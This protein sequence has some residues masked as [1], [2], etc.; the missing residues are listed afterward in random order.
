MV[1][2]IACAQK[3]NWL[4]RPTVRCRTRNEPERR[5]S[6]STNASISSF[7]RLNFFPFY[8]PICLTGA[9]FRKI[10]YFEH[11]AMNI[12][13]HCSGSANWCKRSTKSVL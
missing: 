12:I 7:R 11:C 2:A 8:A 3:S 1:T 5:R 4:V 9:P 6:S 13:A 10:F